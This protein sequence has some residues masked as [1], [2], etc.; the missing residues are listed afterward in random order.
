M[1]GWIMLHRKITEHWIWGDPV[2]LKWWIDILITVNHADEK[3]Q[4][5]VKAYRMQKRS[6][7]NEFAKLGKK[8]GSIK[9]CCTQFFRAF[10]KRRND[11]DGKRLSFHTD[12][13]L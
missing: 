5:G 6:K 3:S 13:C 8:V 1:D 11:R 7:R 4:P 9:R 10:E 12:N 2:K